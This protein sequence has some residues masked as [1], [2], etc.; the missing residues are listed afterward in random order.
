MGALHVQYQGGNFDLGAAMLFL[1][2]AAAATQQKAPLILLL[3][4]AAT[5]QYA[6]ELLQMLQF[7]P[8]LAIFC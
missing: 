4:I 8:F 3:L 7:C 1:H 5:E 6:I 2:C